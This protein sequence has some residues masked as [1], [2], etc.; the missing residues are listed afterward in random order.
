MGHNRY[1]FLGTCRGFSPIYKMG[2]KSHFY[3]LLLLLPL[4]LKGRWKR[5][6]CPQPSSAVPSLCPAPLPFTTS[7]RHRKQARTELKP[8]DPPEE[9]N[10]EAQTLLGTAAQLRTGPRV[11]HERLENAKS[12]MCVSDRARQGVRGS[13]MGA[14]GSVSTPAMSTAPALGWEGSSAIEVLTEAVWEAT[15]GDQSITIALTFL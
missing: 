5:L 15:K 12:R 3:S 7:Q 13:Q 6:S 2:S 4:F 1:Y 9:Q 11:A 8:F 10:L 14:G